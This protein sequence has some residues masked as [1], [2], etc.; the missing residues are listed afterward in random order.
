MQINQTAMNTLKE[1]YSQ[2]AL[3][4][5]AKVLLYDTVQIASPWGYVSING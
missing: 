4:Y 3:V 1:L 2:S 5:V